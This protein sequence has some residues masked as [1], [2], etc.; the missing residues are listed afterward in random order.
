MDKLTQLMNREV[1]IRLIMKFL[2]IASPRVAGGMALRFFTTPQPIP[3]PPWESQLIARGEPLRIAG[4]LSAHRFGKREDRLVLL[5]HGWRGRGAQ[6]G[7]LVEPLLAN[8]F[9]VITLDGPA[10][11]D[12]P[13]S[14]TAMSFFAEALLKVR[15]ELGP[16]YAVVAHSFGAG[17]TAL[18]MKRGLDLKKFVLVA[19]PSRFD[20]VFAGYAKRMRLSS[21]VEREFIRQLVQWTGLEVQDTD[22]AK[23]GEG[24]KVSALVVHDPEDKEVAFQHAERLVAH[25]PG[26]RLLPIENVGHRRILKSEKLVAET[27]AYLLAP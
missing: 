9:Q 26:S 8:G 21:S 6:L 1:I 13:G 20:W 16:V 27:V 15:A 4:G 10:H 25:W 14:R 12:S 23:I 18:A 19:A 17:S 24:L 7:S 22:I 5:V 3:R 11:G 2:S